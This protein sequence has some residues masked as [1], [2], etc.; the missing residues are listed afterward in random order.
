MTEESIRNISYIIRSIRLSDNSNM[1][2]KFLFSYLLYVD[3]SSFKL[4]WPLFWF[5]LTCFRTPVIRTHVIAHL[6]I[7]LL[8]E[9]NQTVL[10]SYFNK[11]KGECFIFRLCYHNLHP[12]SPLCL[13]HFTTQTPDPSNTL[14]CHGDLR[15]PPRWLSQEI[16]GRVAA[17]SDLRT[18]PVN[19]LPLT[20]GGRKRHGMILRM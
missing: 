9:I 14:Y 7:F 19:K 1:L 6:F 18:A 4:A 17:L 12:A 2:T 3:L 5:N 11:L 16:D 15:R 20:A 8:H 10:L 13:W